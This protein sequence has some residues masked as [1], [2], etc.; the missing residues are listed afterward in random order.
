MRRQKVL[1]FAAVTAF[2]LVLGHG[3]AAAQAQAQRA[4]AAAGAPD[5]TAGLTRT[6]TLTPQEELA[7][8]EGILSRMDSSRSVVRRQL[9]TARAQRDVVK[10]LCLNDKLNQLDVAIRSARERRQAL[11]AAAQ[12]QDA[13]LA[14]HE[15]TIL[16]VLRQRADQLTAEANQCIGQEAGFI[17]PSAVQ[18]F[19]DNGIPDEP[20]AIDGPTVGVI[21]TPP[22][23][24]SCVK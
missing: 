22:P 16:S 7:Q 18:A 5:V 11:E 15:F 14:T 2:A 23:C 10:T 3:I 8:S 6:V 19:V 12:R 13:D 17:E 20:P 4:P 24:A 21:V 1:G 9:E